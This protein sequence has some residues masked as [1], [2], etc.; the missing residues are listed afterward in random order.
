MLSGISPFTTLFPNKYRT[1]NK[2]YTMN[3]VVRT[4]D[5]GQ[6]FEKLFVYNC[7]ESSACRYLTDET[8]P[9]HWLDEAMFMFFAY[10]A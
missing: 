9:D 1:T 8:A 4:I 10:T 2:F 7:F 3:A 6:N 5:S